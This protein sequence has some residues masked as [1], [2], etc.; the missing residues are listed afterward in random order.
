MKYVKF[1]I[2]LA[3]IV[4]FSFAAA[5]SESELFT[6]VIRDDA[7]AL[8]SLVA[9]GA[10]PNAVDEGGQPAITRALFQESYVAALA[11]ARMPQLDVNRVN[12]AG[13]TGLMIAALKGR[14]DIVRV[15]LERGAPADSEGWTPLHYA[16]AGDSRPLVALL[17]ARGVRI[18]PRAPNGRTPLMM[19]AAYAGEEA[20]NDLL[21]AGADPAARDRQGLAAADLARGSGRDWLGDKLDAAAARRQPAERR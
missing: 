14:D 16:A 2:Y 5:R 10:D 8:R 4:G 17:L 3:F 13:E 18:D 11:L 12:R 7:A 15:L 6:A 20:V 9:A 1:V 21:R 19:A